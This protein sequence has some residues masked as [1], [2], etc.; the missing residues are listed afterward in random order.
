MT[1]PTK[2]Q[3]MQWARD[4][5]KEPSASWAEYLRVFAALAYAAGAA[6]WR[7]AIWEA[8]TGAG[9]DGFGDDADPRAVLKEAIDWRVQIALDPAV[10][11]EAQALIDRGAAAEREGCAKLCDNFPT[12]H[13]FH[14]CFSVASAIR[15]RGKA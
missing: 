11:E 1:T 6:P 15:A 10:S 13:G 5:G 4:A 14:S 8:R 12:L 3:A 9:L 7:D 2:E